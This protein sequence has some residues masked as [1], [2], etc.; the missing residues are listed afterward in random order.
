MSKEF[1]IGRR[2][3]QVKRQSTSFLSL[4]VFGSLEIRYYDK[5]LSRIHCWV[6]EFGI[7]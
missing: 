2:I 1:A 4:F 7:N 3:Y 5:E 6:Y